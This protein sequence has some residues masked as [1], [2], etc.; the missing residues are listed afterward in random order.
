M[1]KNIVNKEANKETLD[2]AW[3]A[4]NPLSDKIVKGFESCQQKIKD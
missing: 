1:I 2:Q 3:K 4:F